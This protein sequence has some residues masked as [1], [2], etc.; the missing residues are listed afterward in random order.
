MNIFV[1]SGEVSGDQHAARLV[2]EL[3][4]QN[5]S[6]EISFCGGAALEQVTQKKSIIPIERLAIMGFVKVLLNVSKIRQNFKDVYQHL[7]Q[8]QPD[9]VLLVDYPGF[10]LR[11]AKWA[12]QKQI[13]VFYYISPTVW[14]W[15]EKRYL[16]IKHWVQQLYC[17]LPFE[18][19]FYAARDVSVSYFGNPTVAQWME[20]EPLARTHDIALLAGSRMQE[21]EILLPIFSNLMA[22]YPDKSWVV[23]QA[24]G[25]SSEVYHHFLGKQNAYRL[26]KDTQLLLRTAQASVVCS[27]TASLEAGLANCPQVLVYRTDRLS[28][29][30]AKKLVQVKHISLVNLVLDGHWVTELVGPNWGIRE[31]YQ[32]ILE[33]EKNPTKHQYKEKLLDKFGRTYPE[34]QIAEDLLNRLSK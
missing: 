3:L 13:P 1:M 33:L 25:I 6:L 32:A 22:K 12:F 24:P 29:W 30:L 21:L 11:L 20:V 10:N 34:K 15:K 7:S 4:N 26:E 28:F 23:S 16:K 9:A 8:V 31:I 2:A 14:A 19:E 17:I 18:K 27:G 5:P